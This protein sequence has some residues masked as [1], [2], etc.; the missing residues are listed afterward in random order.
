ME[1]TVI[2][3][4]DLSVSRFC[5][6]TMT[7]GGQADKDAA[8]RITDA[9]LDGGVN[10]IDTADIYTGGR[11]EDILG[12]ILKGK[13]DKVILATKVG[14][15]AWD[16]PD[17]QGL[18]R[19][20]ILKSI[21]LSLKR[22]NTD[23][24]D[25]YY[26]HFPDR[27][28]PFEEVAETMNSLIDAG[29]I[30]YYGISNHSAWEIC[31]MAEKAK[32]MGLRPPVIS[33]SVYNVITRGA[34]SELLPFLRAYG[35]GLAVYNPLAG[36]LLTGK[37]QRQRAAEGSRMSDDKGYIARYW[38]DSN[39]DAIDR[40]EEIA[41]AHG[42]SLLEL[43]VRWVLSQKDVTTSLFGASKPEHIVQNLELASKGPLDE[44]ILQ[45][46][47]SVWDSIKGDWFGY[48]R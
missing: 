36:G 24:V 22:L 28:V 37:H 15:P 44:D 33:Q 27:A 30:R 31:S 17:G 13:R 7:F 46:C 23:Y 29:K 12:D 4:T 25:I 3:H 35:I 40:L 38:K 18:G 41:A 48:F 19:D 10:F 34:D 43:S 2:P 16:G 32:N 45:L 21:D 11:S 20:H 1:Y 42:M 5:L 8:L 39:W 9:A 14:G 6:G 47:S 26:M